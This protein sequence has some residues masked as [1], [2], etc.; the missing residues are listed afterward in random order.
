M[1]DSQSAIVEQH[2][3]E[4]PSRGLWYGDTCPGGT[5]QI[6]P[7]TTAQEEALVRHSNKDKMSIIDKM[8]VENVQLPPSFEYEDLLLVD[9]HFL[10]MRLRQVSLVSIYTVDRECPSCERKHE[11]TL[12]LADLDIQFSEPGDEEPWECF[13]PGCGAD[14]TL[15]PLT[16]RD[17]KS[18]EKYKDQTA[19]SPGAPEVR[20]RLAKN[21]VTI[22]GQSMKMDEKKDFVGRLK[23]IDIETIKSVIHERSPGIQTELSVV[24]PKCDSEADFDVPFQVGFFRPKR[25]DIRAASD[26][27]RKRRGRD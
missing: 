25:A 9:Q 7:W 26:L 8:L 15:R 10:L 2:D 1:T 17:G 23:L 4:L 14:V 6:T 13:L 21:I 19:D 5:V 12:D 11:L 27:A 24:C 18:I 22:E 20:L 3:V 16:V